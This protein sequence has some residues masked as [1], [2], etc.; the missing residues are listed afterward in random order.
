MKKRGVL[1]AA[2]FLFL[3][4]FVFAAPQASQ[5]SQAPQASKD[6]WLRK[7]PI[8]HVGAHWHIDLSVKDFQKSRKTLI[9]LLNKHEAVSRLPLEGTGS[10]PEHAYQQ[11]SFILSR[12][13]AQKVFK[14][15]KKMGDVR[16]A[17][18]KDSDLPDYS[19]DIS[20]KLGRLHAERKSGG[21]LL[22]RLTAISSLTDE[23]IRHLETAQSSGETAKK[24]VLLNIVLEERAH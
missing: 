9:R 12:E 22:H 19:Q 2:F 18:Q 15:L 23:L 7:Y 17:H 14:R 21:E 24:T 1:S 5:A 4:S 11:F 10:T 20:I 3:S 8:V 6:F 16:R 13:N